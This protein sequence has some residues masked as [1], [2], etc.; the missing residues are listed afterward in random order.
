MKRRSLFL[1][2]GIL[3]C[4]SSASAA[5][6]VVDAA[7]TYDGEQAS[8]ET[9]VNVDTQADFS[10][11]LWFN[12]T[13]GGD[14]V[15]FGFVDADSDLRFAIRLDEGDS[16]VYFPEV[17]AS[18]TEFRIQNADQSTQY[19]DGQDHQ[20][21]YTWDWD[22]DASAGLGTLWADGAK[23]AD[24]AGTGA[25]P[26][27]LQ[28]IVLFERPGDSGKDP[29]SGTMSDIGLY[30]RVLTSDEISDFNDAGFGAGVPEPATMSLLGL[31]G[32]V[33]LRRRRK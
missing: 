18:P 16:D 30:D 31:G 19:A 13:A 24:D 2:V 20:I 21:V 28:E 23:L 14:E 15:F 4:A 22:S 27:Q 8:V 29:F 12:D 9:G 7:G 33:A 5:L 3:A 26:E 6:T 11:T 25:F 10:I 1:V 32:L 17:N